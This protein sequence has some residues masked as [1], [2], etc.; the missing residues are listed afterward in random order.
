MLVDFEEG[1]VICPHCGSKNVEQRWSV[2]TAIT[3]K[4]SA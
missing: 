2:F 1:E 4:K 3:S